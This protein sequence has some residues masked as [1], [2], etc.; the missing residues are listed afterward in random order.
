MDQL[1]G[2]HD[3]QLEGI[4]TIVDMSKMVTNCRCYDRFEARSDNGLFVQFLTPEQ[5]DKLKAANTP[6]RRENLLHTFFGECLTKP[7]AWRPRSLRPANR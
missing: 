3:P 2:F 7:D 1:A 4:A 5:F 6:V